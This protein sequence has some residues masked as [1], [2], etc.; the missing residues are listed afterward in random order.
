MN[1]KRTKEAFAPSASGS[2]SHRNDDLSCSHGVSVGDVLVSHFGEVSHGDLA[3]HEIAKRG[4]KPVISATVYQRND[5][6]SDG[7][8]VQR[9]F[10]L[11]IRESVLPDIFVNEIWSAEALTDLFARS[12]YFD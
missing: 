4:V 12:A 3:Q 2:H 11:G 9:D 10:D 5:N 6:R 1:H 7:I 8:T